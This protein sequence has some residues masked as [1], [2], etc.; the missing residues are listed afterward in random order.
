MK[1]FDHYVS[2]VCILCTFLSQLDFFP[3]EIWVAF[4]KE[5]QFQQSRATQ[6]VWGA[7]WVFTCYHNPPNSDMDY[8]IFN[9]RTWSFLRV[10]IHTGVGHTDSES[11]QHVWLGQTLTN[12]SCAPDA[13]GIRT[14]SHWLSSLTFYQLS[15]PPSPRNNQGIW[16]NW[17]YPAITIN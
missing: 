15:P 7:W 9:V 4:V 17:S 14:L 5:S 16:E 2:Y 13:D 10:R 11:A 3:W 8:K 6:W 12:R 1:L